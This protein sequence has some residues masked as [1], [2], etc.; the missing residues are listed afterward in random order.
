ENPLLESASDDAVDT[1]DTVAVDGGDAE[2]HW[3]GPS[4]RVHTTGWENDDTDRPEAAGAVSLLY[5]LLEQLRLTRAQPRDV[6]LVS[7]LIDE[8]DENG[9]LTTTLP[10][11]LQALPQQLE[12]VDDDLNTA[13]RLLQ[14]FDPPGV[15]ARSLSECL[16][17][18]L[19][20]LPA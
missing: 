9:Y 16:C 1:G 13:L 14:S 4:D 2:E 7:L 15:G 17:L 6:A 18:Q 8:L 3:A 19:R 12:V 5:H 11:V 20:Q 10:E